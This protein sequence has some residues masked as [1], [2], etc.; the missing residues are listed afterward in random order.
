MMGG[1][2][3]VMA[4]DNVVEHVGGPWMHPVLQSGLSPTSV[5]QLGGE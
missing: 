4:S 3:E 2:P 5:L 1:Q